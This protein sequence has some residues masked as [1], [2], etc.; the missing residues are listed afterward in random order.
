MKYLLDTNICVH[1][2]RYQYNIKRKLNSIDYGDCGLSEITVAELYYGAAYSSRVA[3]QMNLVEK[4]LIHF[5]IIPITNCLPLFGREKARLRKSGLKI[6][7]FDLLIAC[8]AAKNN[9]IM[10]TE[11]LKDFKRVDR[12]QLENWVKR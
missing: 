10:V 8:T 9:L 4:F 11:N 5:T 7:D 3:I 6:S 12:L 2:L 1:F